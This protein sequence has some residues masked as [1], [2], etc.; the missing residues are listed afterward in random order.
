MEDPSYVPGDQSLTA[1]NE[2]RRSVGL[3]IRRIISTDINDFP[4]V[5]H[6]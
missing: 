6:G 5:D 2:G 4:E 1:F 3:S